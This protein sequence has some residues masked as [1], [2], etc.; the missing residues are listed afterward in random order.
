MSLDIIP[1]AV[2]P[3]TL[4][5]MEQSAEPLVVY[6]CELQ[7]APCGMCLEGTTSAV[8]AHLRRHGITGPESAVIAC[9]WGGCNKILKKGSMARHILIHLGVKVRCSICGI[10]KCRHDILRAHI[11]SSE[12]CHF[13]IAED[14]PGPGGYVVAPITAAH[15]HQ[16]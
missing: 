2:D 14:V 12:T 1:V 4:F 3:E 10:V 8:S 5:R 15:M 9:T 16:V 11:N 13:A 7:Q 6:E